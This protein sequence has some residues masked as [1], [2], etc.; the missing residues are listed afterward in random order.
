VAAGEHRCITGD[1]ITSDLLAF[2]RDSKELN[3][4]DEPMMN[5]DESMNRY[6]CMKLRSA[7]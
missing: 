6:R 1:A 4:L 7:I 2:L 5:R 3:D